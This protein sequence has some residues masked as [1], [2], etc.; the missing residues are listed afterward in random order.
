[1]SAR[2]H[3]VS[4]AGIMGSWWT[5]MAWYVL[6]CAFV[7]VPV[8]SADEPFRYP[9]RIWGNAELKYVNQIPV[10]EVRGTPAEI[11][12]QVTRLALQ[13][14][15]RILDYPRDFLRQVHLDVTWPLL[16]TVCRGLAHN[17]PDDYAKE[18]DSMAQ[19]LG[20]PQKPWSSPIPCSMSWEDLA[21]PC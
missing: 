2:K 1:M 9:E 17:I 8:A 18:L 4:L 6:A 21:A 12:E 3:N 14:A 5:R 19:R 10:L 15:V 11:G 7:P 16:A 13:P 20:N